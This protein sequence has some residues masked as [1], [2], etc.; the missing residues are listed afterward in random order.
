MVF[1]SLHS[2]PPTQSMSAV[3][4]I[5]V[6]A[7]VQMLKAGGRSTFGVLATKH[8]DLIT[9]SLGKNGCT[10]VDVVFDWYTAKLIKA[11]E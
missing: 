8:D 1:F 10:R 4:V 5:D 11:G 7:L 6:M 3:H 9:A 2:P